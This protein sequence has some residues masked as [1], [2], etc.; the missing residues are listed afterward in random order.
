MKNLQLYI[1]EKLKITKDN[2]YHY[3]PD[4]NYDLAYQILDEKL[5]SAKNSVLDMTDVDIS[6][7]TSLDSLFAGINDDFPQIEVIDITGWDTSHIQSMSE[8]FANCI[9]VRKIIGIEDLD[10]KSCRYMNSMFAMCRSLKSLDISKWRPSEQLTDISYMF[11]TCHEL[12]KLE[13]I[14]SEI[15]EDVIANLSSEHV[16]KMFLNCEKLKLDLRHW[17]DYKDTTNIVKKCPK[18]KL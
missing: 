15:W 6:N 1:T 10:L 17:W 7:V 11:D 4:N 16:E 12:E 8:M 9:N 2:K 3:Y 18:I 14:E 13:G 5:K